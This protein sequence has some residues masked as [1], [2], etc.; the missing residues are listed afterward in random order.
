MQPS[1][2]VC[3][4]DFSS[5]SS[6]ALAHAAALAA[7][8]RAGL[9]IVHVWAP[10]AMV[11]P[12][13]LPVAILVPEERE[14]LL[15]RLRTLA[16]PLVA[17]GIKAVPLLREG[18]PVPEILEVVR[19]ERGDLLVLGTHGRSGFERLLLGSVTEK[20]LHKA[21]C[22]VLTVPAS[23]DAASVAV[24]YK[25]IVCALD[26]TANPGP[27]LDAA[28]S[29]CHQNDAVLVLTH[30][31]EP[32]QSPPGLSTFDVSAYQAD[33]TREWERSLHE[34]VRSKAGE[35]D[36]IEER[37]PV[38]APA[39]EI[40]RIADDE[41]ADLI[42]MGVRSRGAVDLTLFG[43]ASQAVVRRA[44]CPVLTVRAVE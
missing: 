13:D 28:L 37:V 6:H 2:I 44:S 21:P 38:G 36:R 23:V 10:A 5:F 15:E 19:E 39:A 14:E 31:V 20:L 11:R 32:I 27:G 1:H 18:S 41:H 17:K 25:K 30:V 8:Y 24:N 4:V 12:G 34:L 40:L 33:I 9:T 35:W 42:V 22:P 3:P 43:S 29:L 7:W 16:G 26:Q